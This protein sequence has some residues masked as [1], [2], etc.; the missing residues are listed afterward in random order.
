MIASTQTNHPLVGNGKLA[1]K[2]PTLVELATAKLKAAG[3]RITQ[4]R[5]AIL[6]ALSKCSQPISIEQLH[7]DVGAT[8]CDLVTVYRCVS[9]FEEIGVDLKVTS[10]SDQVFDNRLQ[11]GDFDLA[12]HAWES[13]PEDDPYMRWHSSQVPPTGANYA[14]LKDA[15]LDKVLETAHQSLRLTPRKLS[16]RDSQLLVAEQLPAIPLVYH[17]R[18][19][20]VNKKLYNF[21]P[22][23]W[24]TNDGWNSATWWLDE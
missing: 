19:A 4:P 20:A 5:L 7:A 9:A 17:P 8:N 16:I 18:L 3:L 21:R 24:F 23:P 10:L 12:L 11:K 1:A 13:P 22:S 15:E 2:S 14:R 6:A